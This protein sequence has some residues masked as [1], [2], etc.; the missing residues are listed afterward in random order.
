[1]RFEPS[2]T[3]YG[4]FGVSDGVPGDQGSGR[5]SLDDR[6]GAL[7][8]VEVGYAEA[9]LDPI[10]GSAG[11]LLRGRLGRGSAGRPVVRGSRRQI[12]RGRRIEDVRAKVAVGGWMF[13]RRLEAWTPAEASGRSW[14]VYLLGERLLHQEPDGTGGL[15]GIVRVGTAADA[16]HR[17]DLSLVGGL[18]YRGALAMRP[19]DVVGVGIAHARNGSPFLAF[20]REAGRPMERAETV[21][22]LTYRAQ[23]GRFFVVQPDF[24]WIK[25]PGMDPGADDALVFGLRG[26]FLLEFPEGATGS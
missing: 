24:Q 4:L 16:V 8:S 18:V 9:L 5:F 1:V 22:E 7:L 10:Q 17:L 2:P 14:G 12:G 11:T 15:S 21:L 3:L 23:L 19:D 13:T 20:Q 26:H 6:E 25:D